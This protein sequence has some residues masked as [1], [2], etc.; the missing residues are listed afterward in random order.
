MR[1]DVLERLL[2]EA[3]YP[4]EK[5]KFVVDGFRHGFNLGYRGEFNVKHWSPNLEITISSELELWNKVM[6]EVKE[7][8]YAGPYKEIPYDNYIQSPIGLVPKDNGTKTRLIFHLSYPRG[9]QKLSVNANTPQNLC[10]VKYPDFSEAV[11]MCMNEGKTCKIAKS[12][13]M[14][15]FRHLGL[16]EKFFK[17]L[18]I[19][20]RS[21][22]DNKWYFFVEKCCPF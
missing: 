10:T 22:F 20:A 2:I 14:S 13:M 7:K 19:K 5:R 3:D 15:A 12:D 17:L 16:K 18:I 6:T 9:K 11:Q 1:A 21:P 8:H 4:V